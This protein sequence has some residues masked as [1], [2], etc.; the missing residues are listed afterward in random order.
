MSNS[1]ALA[2]NPKTSPRQLVE[3]AADFPAEVAAN[4]SALRQPHLWQQAELF[5]GLSMASL[6]SA[7]YAILVN[8]A[9]H[10]RAEI[11]AAVAQNSGA[12]EDLLARLCFDAS[13][14]VR[15]AAAHNPSTP[16]CYAGLIDALDERERSLAFSA[17][18]SGE[19]YAASVSFTPPGLLRAIASRSPQLAA[20]VLNNPSCPAGMLDEFVDR[21]IAE[22]TLPGADLSEVARRIG[23]FSSSGPHGC[24]SVKVIAH[25]LARAGHDERLLLALFDEKVC[26]SPRFGSA[27]ASVRSLLDLV[28]DGGAVTEAVLGK[29]A[30][31][32]LWLV[33]VEAARH[34]R[35]PHKLLPLLLGDRCHEVRR[36]AYRHPKLD[37]SWRERLTRLGL[38]PGLPPES[39]L[40]SKP[41]SEDLEALRS[42]GPWLRSLTGCSSQALAAAE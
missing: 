38:P 15:S 13:D 21:A 25:F 2:S 5:A 34:P 40:A 18:A 23:L 24:A 4:P 6:P 39:R 14:E 27:E 30:R 17:L 1:A 32:P 20:S 16:A 9:V 35:L 7:P 42:T 28:L 12:R 36:A 33:R 8:M 11:R 10:A 3:L 26:L 31:H 29:M 19:P 41:G 37:A 22:I